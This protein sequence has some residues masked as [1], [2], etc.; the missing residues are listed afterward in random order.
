VHSNCGRRAQAEKPTF[1]HFTPLLHTIK[2]TLQ[3]VKHK[4][5]KNPLY[6][7]HLAFL[8]VLLQVLHKDSKNRTLRLNRM[9]RKV[10]VIYEDRPA[11]QAKEKA[12]AGL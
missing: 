12:R 7:G 11:R 5:E 3:A 4:S 2:T 1:L 6:D 10:K 8:S 9:A